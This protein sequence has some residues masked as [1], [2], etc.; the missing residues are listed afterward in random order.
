MVTELGGEIIGGCAST[1]VS[2]MHSNDV[3]SGREEME[4]VGELQSDDVCDGADAGGGVEESM[5]T[6]DEEQQPTGHHVTSSATE[7][8][9]ERIGGGE[10]DVVEYVRQVRQFY[11]GYEGYP[12]LL[13]MFEGMTIETTA[14]PFPDWDSTK[15]Q[16][17]FDQMHITG[18][19]R[20]A[21]ESDEPKYIY[22]CNC[23]S[24]GECSWKMI[25]IYH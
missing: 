22:Y 20:V 25:E 14:S 8:T 10:T 12:P 18:V 6:C 11:Q 23:C 16:L 24:Q 4:V 3:L 5:H 13:Y 19:A 1:A 7:F 15:K 2:M 17:S 21:S 9:C